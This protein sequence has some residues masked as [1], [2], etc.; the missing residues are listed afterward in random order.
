MTKLSIVTIT[1]RNPA[2]LQKTLN[3]LIPLLE[4]ELVWE[5]LVV[6][7]APELSGPVLERLDGRLPVRHVTQPPLGIYAA[8]NLGVRSARGELLW[9]LNSGD[10]LLDLRALLDM[11]RDFEL[12]PGLELLCGGVELG[13]D[14]QVVERWP[15][16]KSFYRSMLGSQGAC[17]QGMLYAASVFERVGPYSEAYLIAGDYDHLVRCLARGIEVRMTDRCLALYDLSGISQ[18]RI[19]LASAER[20][21]ILKAHRREFD[22]PTNRL[23]ELCWLMDAGRSAV[24]RGVNGTFLEEPAR[25]VLR[26]FRA[27][28]RGLGFR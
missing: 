12:T 27:G 24:G 25:R 11:I 3:S 6:D 16:G 13:R 9:F 15:P 23:H 18:Q 8:L 5:C 28:C 26:A 17:H 10:C 19:R 22:W 21:Q 2:G 7:S 4:C 20:W 1:Y 14:G